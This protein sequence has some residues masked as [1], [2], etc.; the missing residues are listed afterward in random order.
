MSPRRPAPDAGEGSQPPQGTRLQKWLA[1]A[2][3]CSRREGEEWIRAGRV[4]LNGRVVTELGT[5]VQEGDKVA[6]DGRVVLRE[7]LTRIVVALHKPVGVLCTRHDPEGRRTVFD[8]LGPGAPARLVLVGRLD[9]NSEGLLLLTSDG[10]LAYRLMRPANRVPRVYRVKVHGRLDEGVL[11][12]LARGV[13]LEDGPTG[14]IEF[15]VD[16]VGEGRIAWLTLTLHEGRNRLIRRL[17]AHLGLEVARLLR[18]SFGGVELGDLPNG[19]WRVLEEG[20]VE[21]LRRGV[22]FQVRSAPSRGA[23][24][25]PAGQ[26]GQGGGAPGPARGGRR[27][28]PRRGGGSRGGG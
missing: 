25:T 3:L 27:P 28:P 8:L 10:L 13:T 12:Q 15:T 21:G 16:R 24:A 1:E 14:P 4:A 11:D 2:G 7:R 19:R 6:V 5:R 17:F 22:G 23:S 20:E 18:V 26:R 9:Y